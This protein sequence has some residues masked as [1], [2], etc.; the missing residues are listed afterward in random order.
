MQLSSFVRSS[1]SDEE[2]IT[3][4]GIMIGL[5]VMSVAVG[6]A[7]QFLPGM[8]N[9]VN[10]MMGGSADVR[11][12]SNI[13]DLYRNQSY[14][15]IDNTTVIEAEIVPDGYLVTGSNTIE[16]SWNGEVTVSEAAGGSHFALQFDSLPNETC[17]DK[18]TGNSSWIQIDI[19]G[20][21]FS[22]TPVPVADA[23]NNCNDGSGN[24]VTLYQR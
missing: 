5:A 17:I 14:A 11:F 1:H 8:L 2:G 9:Q 12:A 24:T 7:Y 15:G 3:L 10:N 20:T 22:E 13:Q 23:T 18:A 16:H 19:N 21:S 6:A 4:Y